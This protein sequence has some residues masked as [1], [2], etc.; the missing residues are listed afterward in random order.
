MARGGRKKFLSRQRETNPIDQPN[1]S[2]QRPWDAATRK[3]LAFREHTGKTPANWTKGDDSA[4]R[5]L[6]AGKIAAGRLP[7]SAREISIRGQCIE[8]YEAALSNRDRR[9]ILLEFLEVHHHLALEWDWFEKR[10]DALAAAGLPLYAAN[11]NQAPQAT[12]SSS[13]QKLATKPKGFSG[14]VQKKQ[15]LSRYLDSSMLTDR[16]RDCLSLKLEYGLG[17]SEIARRIG[18]TRK[19]VDEHIKAGGMALERECNAEKNAKK[20]AARVSSQVAKDF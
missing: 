1:A 18:I 5:D 3:K 9:R 11:E 7:P 13:M 15:D 8:R 2:P 17:V 6:Q 19:T 16:Q 4:W 20:R 14:L 10:R 12:I